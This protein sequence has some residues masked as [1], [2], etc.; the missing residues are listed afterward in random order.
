MK[1]DEKEYITIHRIVAEGEFVAIQSE[2]TIREQI[3]TFWDIL[4]IDVNELIVEQ[5]QAVAVFPDNAEHSNGP[6]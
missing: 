2:G 4:R 5:W 1:N 3:H 6:F